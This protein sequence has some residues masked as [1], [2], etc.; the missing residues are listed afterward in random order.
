MKLIRSFALLFALTVLSRCASDRG[1]SAQIDSKEGETKRQELAAVQPEPSLPPPSASAVKDAHKSLGQVGT[2]GPTEPE[3]STENYARFDENPFMPAEFEP[4]STFSIDVDT[5]SYS[6]VRRFL[7]SGQVPPRDAVRIEELINYFQYDDPH[8]RGDEPFA[9]RAELATCPWNERHLLL[10]IGLKGRPIDF[11]S[12]QP[13]DYVFL[14]DTSGSMQSPDKLPL[15]KHALLRLSERLGAQDRIAI[16]AYAGSAGLVL[17]PTPGNARA[18]I[19]D[20]LEQLEAGGS[21]AGGAGIQLAYAVAQGQFLRGGIN[22]VI[23]AT[24]GDFNVGVSS[25]GELTRLVE[26]RAKSGVFLTVLGFGT[27]N[28]KDSALEALADHGN[29]NYAY[30]DNKLEAERALVAQAGG[31]LITVAKDVKIQVEFNPA[32]VEGYRLIG[33][34]NR[35]L[36]A[37]DFNDD[38]KDAGEIGAGISVTALYE[39]IPAGSGELTGTIDRLR[40]SRTP[41]ASVTQPSGHSGEWALVKLRY[42]Q[43]D[44]DVSHLLELPVAGD[45]TRFD[46]ASTDLRFSSAVAAFGMRLRHSPHVGSIDYPQ[47]AQIAS[48]ALGVVGASERAG[49]IPLVEQA[50]RLDRSAATVS[51]RE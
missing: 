8:P 37:V 41:T 5:A 28:L 22:R 12:R 21:T 3:F 20:A 17:P 40:Y 42:K 39:L 13:G 19:R 36:N 1:P 2:A 15:V 16:V 24:D 47:I 48:T 7:T 43:P 34:E 10:R 38:Q 35:R 46:A 32:R 11:A 33:Y 18:A 30:I 6:N 27:G 31:T 9:T 44:A 14:I 26:E 51:S 50:G 25:E 45:P 29:G 49:L 4:L 23:L